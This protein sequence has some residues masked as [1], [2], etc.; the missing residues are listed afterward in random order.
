MSREKVDTPKPLRT[1]PIEKKGEINRDVPDK[2]EVLL[3]GKYFE[4]MAKSLMAFMATAVVTA[5]L[6]R[7][8]SSR[9]GGHSKGRVLSIRLCRRT[10]RH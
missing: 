2:L 4:L 6:R 7:A 5:G 3:G 10:A 1:Q 9:A 8:L